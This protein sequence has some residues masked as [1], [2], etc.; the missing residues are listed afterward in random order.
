MRPTNVSLILKGY[1]DREVLFSKTALGRELRDIP[2]PVLDTDRAV[3]RVCFDTEDVNELN[4][5]SFEV[6]VNGEDQKFER[7][8]CKNIIELLPQNEFFLQCLHKA[9]FFVRVLENKSNEYDFGKSFEILDTDEGSRNPE[10]R[11]LIGIEKFVR[12]NGALFI[13]NSKEVLTRAVAGSG[14]L[15]SSARRYREIAEV[16]ARYTHYFRMNARFKLSTREAVE[17]FNRI[18]NFS[19]STLRYII[20]H[21]YELNPSMNTKGILFRG[22]PYVPHHTLVQTKTKNFAIYENKVILGFLK[23]VCL[24][25]EKYLSSDSEVKKLLGSLLGAY[26]SALSLSANELKRMPKATSIFTT[27]GAYRQFFIEIRKWFL[28]EDKRELV[29]SF[30]LEA[31][32]KGRLYE[33]YCLIKL[34]QS[35]VSAGWELM[36][37]A[38]IDWQ[39]NSEMYKKPGFD[40]YFKFEKEGRITEVFFEPVVWSKKAHLNERLGLFRSSTVRLS[41]SSFSFSEDMRGFY[42]P[43]YVE[44][45]WQPDGSRLFTISDAKFSYRQTVVNNSLFPLIVKYWLGISPVR[46]K[47]KVRELVVFCG[48][49]GECSPPFCVIPNPLSGKT[50]EWVRFVNLN[51]K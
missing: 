22:T 1:P 17:P 51:E 3:L 9:E 25:A 32:S 45:E 19:D 18:R 47:D 7:H 11:I 16:Y 39:C 26:E 33:Y 31:C 36:D 5:F 8:I 21:P 44:R 23:T 20:S 10:R 4:R 28:Q 42:L 14:E 34:L 27:V 12:D 38:L 46:E 13:S 2:E 43:D 50:Y 37:S 49:G 35:K 40:N 6:K 41:A 29:D 24:S 30:V 15:G 48:K